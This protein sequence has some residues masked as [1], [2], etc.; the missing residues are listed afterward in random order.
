M[1][2]YETEGLHQRLNVLE[3]KV[4]QLEKKALTGSGLVAYIIGG[5]LGIWI[6]VMLFKWMG[7]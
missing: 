7:R 6:V 1:S 2:S 4:E 3:Q 5:L